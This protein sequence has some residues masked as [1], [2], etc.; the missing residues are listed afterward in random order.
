VVVS[1]HD[2]SAATLS[3][4]LTRFMATVHFPIAAAS[5]TAGASVAMM[6]QQQQVQ[7]QEQA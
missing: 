1:S 7:Q 3:N 4:M 5:Q 6:R 2:S